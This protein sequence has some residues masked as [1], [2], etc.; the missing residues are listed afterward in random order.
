MPD[1]IEISGMD[2][3]KISFEEL[4]KKYPDTAGDLLKKDALKLRREIVGRSRELT[5]IKES[6][7][8]LGKL[9]S[10]KVSQIQGLGKNQYVEISAKAPH[11][12]LVEKGHELKTASGK[13]IGFVQGVHF[14]DKATKEYE[15]KYEDH[16]EKMIENLLKKEKLI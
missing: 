10:Y 12:H 9:S 15:D 13:T 8:S 3:L 1:S 7:H 11:F 6:K 5:N 14:L 2:E 4:A 16:V